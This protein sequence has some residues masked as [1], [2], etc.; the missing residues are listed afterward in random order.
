MNV[1]FTLKVIKCVLNQMADTI[2]QDVIIVHI[3]KN[4]LLL[5]K[6]GAQ[7]KEEIQKG[8]RQRYTDQIRLL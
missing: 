8:S 6:E 7:G 5:H 3:A 1:V 4:K 2:N